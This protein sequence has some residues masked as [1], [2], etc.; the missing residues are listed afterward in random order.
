MTFACYTNFMDHHDYVRKMYSGTLRH[1]KPGNQAVWSEDELLAGLHHFYELHGSFPK[2][3]E[4]DTFEY[5]P[6]SRSIQRTHGGLVK[7]RSKLLPMEIADH[8]KGIHRSEVAKRTF[9]QGRDYEKLFFE[10]LLNYFEEIAVH[11][12][13]LIRPGNVNSDFFIY[14]SKN[15][16]IVIDI[17]YANSVI[18]LVNVVNLKLKRYALIQPET[19]LVVVGNEEISQE[20][21]QIK[22]ENRKIPLPKH[23]HIASEMYFKDVIVPM[24]RTRSD[25]SLR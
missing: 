19:Y 12:H 24:L 9:A 7:L 16:G 23:V 2:A 4:I 20:A 13:K 8:T 25:Y 3:H 5:L 1:N 17:F 15:T 21:I 14:L 6:S 18:N 10:Y 11:E 22:V